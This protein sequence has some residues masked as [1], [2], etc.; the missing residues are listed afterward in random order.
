MEIDDINKIA[1]DYLPDYSIWRED[2]DIVHRYKQA[3]LKLDDADRIIFLIY[4]E[5][6]SLRETGKKLGVS[7]TTI[8]KELRKIKDKLNEYVRYI[9]D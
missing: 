4:V 9:S 3:L 7:H 5:T 1:K 8:Y 6:Q 2:D